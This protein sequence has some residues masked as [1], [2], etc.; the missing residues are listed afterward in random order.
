MGT[1]RCRVGK[2]GR[3]KERFSPEMEVRLR[4]IWRALTESSALPRVIQLGGA[5]LLYCLCD[6]VGGHL[7]SS[8]GHVFQLGVVRMTSMLEVRRKGAI[9]S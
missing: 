8:E 6:S 3:G 1:C 9:G 2:G 5:Y 4:F 7:L